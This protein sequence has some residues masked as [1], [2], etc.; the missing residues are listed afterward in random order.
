MEL[1]GDPVVSQEHIDRAI[2]FGVDLG[3]ATGPVQAKKYMLAFIQK[4]LFEREKLDLGLLTDYLQ[5]SIIK[6]WQEVLSTLEN[7]N[8]YFLGIQSGSLI[9]K[10][11]CP[12]IGCSWELANDSW[13]KTLT[14]NMEK[15]M[16]EIGQ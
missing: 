1:D 12:T 7:S 16:H 15:F 14:Q 10:L 13:I 2:K 3:N 4:L 9:F 8:R 11:F 6:L 5:S